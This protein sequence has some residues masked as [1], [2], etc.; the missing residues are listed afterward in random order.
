MSDQN[1][2]SISW[3]DYD[4]GKP[5]Q[6]Q[7]PFP[8]KGEYIFQAPM[9]IDDSA[10]KTGNDG[11]QQATLDPC[12]IVGGEYGGYI[13]R[14]VNLSSKRYG[15]RNACSMG[16]YLLACNSPFRPQNNDQW[17]QAVQATAGSTFPGWGDWEAYDKLNK[18]TIC[19]GMDNFPLVDGPDGTKVRQRYIEVPDATA[20]DG[21]RR[22]WANFKIKYFRAQ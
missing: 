5:Q 6:T 20:P 19:E 12:T 22:V 8:P 9:T 4:K 16:D 15:N 13:V 11:Q 3:A 1:Q 17:K 14:F 18:K 2:T 10:F 7:K 21:K